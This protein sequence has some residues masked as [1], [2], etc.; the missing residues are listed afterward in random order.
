MSKFHIISNRLPYSISE[1]DSKYTLNASVGGLATGL[2]S[3]YR[4]LE[5]KWIG[6]SGISSD[7]ITI[8]E[9]LEIDT[10]LLAE[11]CLPVHLTT[12]EIDSYYEGFSNNTIWPLFHYF[13]QY[14]EFNHEKWQVYKAVN[15][16]FA[17]AALAILEDG[18]TIWVNDYQLLLVPEMI[19]SR[20]PD[21]TI[22]FFLHIPFPSY[23]IFRLLPW[24]NEMINGILGADLI[25]FH[26]FDYERHFISCV[27]R[28]IG[29]EI[30]LNQIIT[31]ERIILVDAFPMGI[32]YKKFADSASE[33][34]SL[35]EEKKSSFHGELDK[36]S[37]S[38]P[39]RKLILSIDRLDY[40]KGIPHRLRA[41]GLFLEM[42]PEMRGLVSLIL[43]AVPSRDQVEHY[44][45]LKKE[46][47]EL[48]GG[49]NGQYGDINYTPIWYFYRSMPFN[50]LVE[51]YHKSDIALVTPVRDGMNLVAKEYVASRSNKDGVIILSEM[52]G[53]AKEMGEAIIINP[54]NEKEIAN[55]IYE[56]IKMPIEEQKQRITQLQT[57]LKRYDLFK[58]TSEFMK[59]LEKVKS[60]QKDYYAKKINDL[61]AEDIKNTYLSASQRV[62][63]LDYDGTLS[64][65][66]NDPAMAYPD[67]E[68]KTIIQDLTVI[69]ENTVT[70]ISGRD[71]ETLQDWFDGF[72]VNLI[73]EHGVWIRKVGTDWDMPVF[74]SKTWMETIRPLLENF[75]DNTPGTFI[76]EKNF[77]LVWHYRK[78]EP[79]HGDRRALELKDELTNLIGNQNIEIME[80]NRVIE[81]KN[82]GINK[83]VAANKFLLT[84]PSDFIMAIGDDWTDEYMF[85]E[86]PEKAITIKVGIKRTIAK[87]K[88]E[89]VA[90]VRVLLKKLTTK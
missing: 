55:A 72:K 9:Q 1:D 83:G 40:S 32:D 58:W 28:L 8:E 2:S 82:G 62:I 49:I 15:L 54:N 34:S 51:L 78:A 10:L 4:Q 68:L 47:D 45:L 16:K 6:W 14:A 19:K 53:V 38:D 29:F 56:A 63:F 13:A 22:G 65:F 33:L 48:V 41:F 71:K 69:P 87:Y 17:E 52:A 66:K 25:G 36:F 59:S 23:E 39:N 89:S 50:N 76:E 3:V 11:D 31:D 84:H 35:P 61:V 81:V 42:H 20:M 30:N 27:R 46:V 73:A 79:E 67:D 64:L 37:A 60:I 86:L 90:N 7:S 77:S 74:A 18:D 44:Q 5:G 75:V 21:V 26:T 57:R 70:I 43:L 80:G 12:E 88:L 24:R 85:K